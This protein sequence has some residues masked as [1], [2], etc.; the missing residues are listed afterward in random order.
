VYAYANV[1]GGDTNH[2][3]KNAYANVFGGDTNHGANKLLTN[4]EID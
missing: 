1:V 4:S 3:A 2:G